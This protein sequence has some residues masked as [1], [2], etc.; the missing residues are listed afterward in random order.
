M[1]SLLRAPA[2]WLTDRR[3]V[4]WVLTKHPL[5]RRLVERFVA[6]EDL[7]A[8]MAAARSLGGAGIATMLDHLGENVASPQGAAE[9]TDAY[10]RALKRIEEAPELDVAIS[11]KLT[12]LGLDVSSRL[13]LENLERVLQAAARPEGGTL[14]M[15]DMEASR[16]V[17]PILE[18]YLQ[19]RDR[20]PHVGVC[21]Q[22]YLRRTPGDARRIAAPGAVVRVVKGA[23]LEPP[24]VALAGRGEVRRAFARVAATLL[25]SGAVVHV[26]THDRRL[27]EGARRFVR[28]RSISR[29]RY[30]FQMLY[31]VRR[32]LQAA[33][34][35]EGEPV[36]VYVPYGTQW[37][38][39]LA[40]RLAERPANMW[41]F[42]SNLARRGG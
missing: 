35:R 13:C 42:L 36:R 30:E 26:A 6:G 39:Y 28:V 9:A 22:S 40:R 4:R 29:R 41:F 17:D 3:P 25:G 16:Y 8:A 33:L 27:I 11:V 1:S 12:Q 7:E 19:V 21:L 37:Y 34:V 14:V 31:G 38:P 18:A 2:I 23:Y 5:G 10:V 24:G 32:D 20:Y 15:V